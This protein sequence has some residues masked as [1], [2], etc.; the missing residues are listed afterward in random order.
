MLGDFAENYQILIQDEVQGYHWNS[1][2]CTVHPVMIYF[3]PQESSEKLPHSPLCFISDMCNTSQMAVLGSTKTKNTS[4][5]YAITKNISSRMRVEYF[6]ATSYG[7]SPCG[8]IGGTDLYLKAEVEKNIEGCKVILS[9]LM[10]RVDK[11]SANKI[12]QKLNKKIQSLGINAIN[13]DNISIN[14]IGRK[15]LHLNMKGINK[16]GSNI[17][18]K[19]KSI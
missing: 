11:L 6:F 9:L 15:G 19:L 3:R 5:T 14:D 18:A 8:G 16:L 12:I 17:A 7:K 4:S 1:Q 10:Q 2:Q 13:N